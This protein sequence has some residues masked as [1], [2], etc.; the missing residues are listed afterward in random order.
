[1][2]MPK[3]PPRLRSAPALIGIALARN[4][5]AGARLALFLR[6]R[7]FDYRAAPGHFAALFAFNLGVWLAAAAARAGFGG[8]FDPDAVLPNL[9]AVPLVLGAAFAVAALYGRREIAPVLATALISADALFEIVGLVLIMLP[10]EPAIVGLLGLARLVWIWV[11]A[12]RAVAVCAG[13]RRPQFYQGALVVSAL[14]AALFAF[15]TAEPWVEPEEPEAPPPLVEEEFFHLQG[16]LIERAL[17][18]IAAGRTG[19]PEL[20]FVG[21][22]PDG[23]EEVFLDEMRYVKQLF[24]GRFGTRGRSVA[25]VNGERALD[26]FPIASATNLRR[27]LERVAKRMNPD[28]DAVFLFLSGHGDEGHRLAAW[29]PPLELAAVTPTSLARMLQDIGIRW[30]VIVVSA[31]YSG[32]FVEPLRDENTMIITAS[33]ADRPSFGCEPGQEFT[34]FGRAYFVEALE[35]TRSFIEAFEIAR[36]TLARQETREKLEA[37]MPQISVGPAIERRLPAWEGRRAAAR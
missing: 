36:E 37:S 21:F 16:E 12:L 34:Y 23:S 25:L 9:A 10:V 35:R 4:L 31:C 14:I 3:L 11:V 18:S 24:D 27:V 32:G 17:A 22:A 15:P 8:E 5:A 33:A 13:T 1:M 26:E 29:E 28:E 6:L 30:K 2:T 7:R 20:Y 19:V